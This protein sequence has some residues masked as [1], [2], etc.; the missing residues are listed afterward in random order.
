MIRVEAIILVAIVVVVIILLIQTSNRTVCDDPT[1][2]IIDH[3]PVT[4]LN[5][6]L[7]PRLHEL[8]PSQA[9]NPSAIIVGNETL[10]SYRVSTFSRCDGSFSEWYY[11]HDPGALDST[12]IIQ[13]KGREIRLDI[14]ALSS[15]SSIQYIRG[16]EDLRLFTHDNNVYGLCNSRV[17]KVLGVH[18]MFIVHIASIYDLDHLQAITS[19]SAT[20][21]TPMNVDSIYDKY[22][23][24]AKD[25]NNDRKAMQPYPNRPE[26]NWSGWSVDGVMYITYSLI[27]HIIFAVEKYKKNMAEVNCRIA[28]ATVSNEVR[29]INEL[30]LSAGPIP[31][32]SAFLGIAHTRKGIKYTHY[33][34]VFDSKPPH[35]ILW[36]SE[37]WVITDG[38]EY[39][40]GMYSKNNDIIILY[41]YSDCVP[42]SVKIP[43]TKITN[44]GLWKSGNV[45]S[46]L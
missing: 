3:E 24:I 43:L 46:L 6:G 20:L 15:K 23:M 22:R 37:G 2:N 7:L 31:I 29:D 18:R 17:E 10:H 35:A 12:T 32:D 45:T 25:H 40:S 19:L 33:W 41:G 8:M 44:G 26:K 38:K 36:I 34:Y 28:Y 39:V 14:K 16:Y 27:P 9:Y 21:L 4:P 13:W 5:V 1:P 30:R 11:R 42:L